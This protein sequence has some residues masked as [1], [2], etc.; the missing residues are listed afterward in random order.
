MAPHLGNGAKRKKIDFVF[1]APEAK[2]VYLA[3]SFNGWS[4]KKHPM[5]KNGNGRWKKTVILPVG[6]HEYKFWVDGRWVEDPQ[7]ERR[8]INSFGSVNSIVNIWK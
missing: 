5:E 6:S 7:N 1:D 2:E 3:G 4:L 8:C